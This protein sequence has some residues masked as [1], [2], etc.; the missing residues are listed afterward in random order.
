M[1]NQE[2]L[3]LVLPSEKYKESFLNVFNEY[4]GDEIKD[5]FN[6]SKF[7]PD[8]SKFLENLKNERE[9][10]YLKEGYVPQTI[11]WL[12][13]G[14]RFI[15]RVGIRHKLTEKL[16]IVGGHLGYAIRP[17]ERGKGYGS[18]ALTLGLPKAKELGLDSV[19]ITCKSTNIAS[20]KIIEKHGGVF[21]GLTPF[22]DADMLR[23]W[24]K[25]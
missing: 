13:K 20:K 15:G 14:D 23:Y 25:T 8:F 4:T 6:L 9:G 11:Y 1:N 10:K 22:E 24:V 5:H 17:S 2:K 21:E 18:L 19:L 16:K 3:E 7:D 12:V